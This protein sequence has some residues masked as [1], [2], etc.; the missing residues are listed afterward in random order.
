MKPFLSCNHPVKVNTLKGAQLVPCGHCVQCKVSRQKRLELLLSLETQQH[1]Y[2]ELIN[3]TY[4]DE[5]IP[6]IDLSSINGFSENTTLDD[7]L[8]I[9]LP[10]HLGDR[11]IKRYN[12]KTK[13]YM[14]IVDKSALGR[15]VITPYGKLERYVDFDSFHPSQLLIDLQ[16]YNKRINQYYV[17]FPFR[18]R[19]VSRQEN[20]VAILLNEDLQKFIDRLQKW[21]IRKFGAKTRYFAVGEYGTNSLRPHWHIIL[22][23]DSDVLRETFQHVY[24]YPNSTKKNPRECASTLFDDEVWTFGDITTTTTDGFASSY[25]SGYL[26]S[27]ANL[28]ALLDPFPQKTFKSIFLGDNRDKQYIAT[29][30]KERRYDELTTY[31]IKG[32]DAISRL[33]PVPSSS[34]LRYH[35]GYSFDG[36]QD[37][38]SRYSL[39]YSAKCFLEQAPDLNIYDDGE[40]YK[41]LTSCGNV[42]S[43]DVRFKPLCNYINDYCLPVWHSKSSI[44]PLKSLFYATKKLYKM[45]NYLGFTP[46]Q[47][48]VYVER[49]EKWLDYQNL[50]QH[51]QMLQCDA[52]FSYQYYSTVDYA[53][54]I[55]NF[56]LYSKTPLFMRQQ[57]N[58]NMDYNSSIKHREVVQ[59]YKTDSYV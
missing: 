51:F 17:R 55:P 32:R 57:Q 46:W 48:L 20:H 24:V 15:S 37:V 38:A 14:K 3:L 28:P 5:F 18:K 23:H 22:F 1:K 30:F 12:P 11:Y 44:H 33:V 27:T 26:N 31:R 10:L 7:F 16:D 29:L 36:L 35:I 49:F 13:D 19:G 56:K 50:V 45:S 8:R 2:S 34:Y 43:F 59:T 53:L 21:C 40:I 52:N 39:L 25:L 47:Y 9:V 54:G 4:S 41:V 42:L 6:W 58:A